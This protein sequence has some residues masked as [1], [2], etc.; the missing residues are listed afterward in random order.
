MM[1]NLF[2]LIIG[3]LDGTI[4]YVE[5][6]GTADNPV[7][8]AST[9]NFG[10]ISVNNDESLYGFSTPFVFEENNEINILIGTESGRIYHYISVNKNLSSNFELVSA[11]FQSIKKG[12]NTALLD[13]FTNDGKRDMFLGMQ[14]GG[15][16]YYVNDSISTNLYT[17]K[18][19]LVKTYPN[20]SA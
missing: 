1:M 10:G 15:L 19:I 6:I 20:P 14:S 11:D 4:T 18:K 16:F 17:N 9:E 13:D 8:N 2:D 12:K 5:N 7:F 3:Q